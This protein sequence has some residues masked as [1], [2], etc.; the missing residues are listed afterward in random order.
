GMIGVNSFEE[1]SLKA[2]IKGIYKPQILRNI[3][4]EDPY[5]LL[6]SILSP[7]ILLAMFNSGSLDHA[8]EKWITRDQEVATILGILLELSKKVTVARTLNEQMNVIEAH[9]SYMI[10][11]M[12]VNGKRTVANAL[13]H[14]IIRNLAAKRDANRS[15][16]EQG[17]RVTAFATSQELLEKNLGRTLRGAVGRINLVGKI[18]CN[19]TLVTLWKVYS[20]AFAPGKSRRFERQSKRLLYFIAHKE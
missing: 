4:E 5:V 15:L 20:D 10:D 6:L 12:W 16:I 8:L 7:R 18:L 13:S 9:A 19:S 11:N 1:G 17:H 2:I 3:L 14:Q